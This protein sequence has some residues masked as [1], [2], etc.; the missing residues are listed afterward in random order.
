L[1]ECENGWEV[2]REAAEGDEAVER[3]RTLHPDVVV[4]SIF[5]RWNEGSHSAH[6]LYGIAL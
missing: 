2:C 3:S 4:E 5:Q 1:L 6:Q